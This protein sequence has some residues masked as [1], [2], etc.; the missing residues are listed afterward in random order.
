MARYKEGILGGFYGSVGNVIGSSW[1]GVDYMR[2]R[3]A[4]VNDAKTPAQ[5]AQRQKFQ[6][7]LHFLRRVKPMINLGFQ[8]DRPRT[9]SMNLASSYN[10]KNAIAG[11]YP[12]QQIDFPSLLI[13]RGDLTGNWSAVA[14][15][16]DPGEIEFSWP[17]N[18]ESGSAQPD[19]KVMILAYDPVRELPVY[20]VDAAERQDESAALSLPAILEGE[21]VEC[22]LAFVSPDDK[23]ASDSIY[24]GSVTVTET[25]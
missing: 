19:D 3:P 11:T 6:L 7:I 17:D 1:R 16:N 12:D 15:S 18:S 22:Y 5:L 20:Q 9:T 21:T 14:E 8:S 13:S 4:R 24:L 2:S 10:L 23:E 25:P